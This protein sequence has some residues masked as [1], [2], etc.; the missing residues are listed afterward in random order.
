LLMELR[1]LVETRRET[2]PVHVFPPVI[3]DFFLLGV[4]RTLDC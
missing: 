1:E 2:R 4:C 3:P